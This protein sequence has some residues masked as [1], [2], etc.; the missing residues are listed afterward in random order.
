MNFRRKKWLLAY[1][2][3]QCALHSHDVSLK[4]EFSGWDHSLVRYGQRKLRREICTSCFAFYTLRSLLWRSRLRTGIFSTIRLAY[5]NEFLAVIFHGLFHRPV[6]REM[7]YL[8]VKGPRQLVVL[9]NP[10]RFFGEQVRRV[11]A[12]DPVSRIIAAV[13]IVTAHVLK[14]E[15]SAQVIIMVQ[16]HYAT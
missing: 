5:V 1:S 13:H 12:V 14:N 9:D 11:F 7:R 16:L 6:N 3:V 15:R 10:N 2:K 8:E 4:P